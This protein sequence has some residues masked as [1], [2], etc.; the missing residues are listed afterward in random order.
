MRR[1]DGSHGEGGGQIL[2]SALALSILT[3][4]A[5]E[6]HD[7]RAGRS[8]PGLMPQHLKAVNAAAA[9]SKATVQGAVQG[10]T[11]LV[12]EPGPVRSGTWCF[13]IGTA[14]A[15]SLVLQTI[16]LPLAFAAG[17]SRVTVTGGT[18][19][20]WSPCYHYLAEQWIPWMRQ[21]GVQ[22]DVNMERAGF[23]PR[24]GGMIEARI[25]PAKELKPLQ[26]MERGSLRRI[27]ILSMVADLPESIALRQGRA[28]ED[29]LASWGGERET[30]V[31]TVP[32]AG[33]G[34][35]LFLRADF[36]GGHCSYF[37]LGARGKPAEQV[38]SEAAQALGAFLKSGAAVD[39]H[40]ADQ[41]VLPL[42]L[43]GG[44]S[45][46]RTSCVTRHLLT[47]IWVT[48]QFLPAGI[49]VEG[50]PGAPG[51]VRI[52]GVERRPRS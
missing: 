32:A 22:A 18:H 26:L 11:S 10:S 13:E 50:V 17:P 46:Y 42:A 34:T 49:A 9:V 24:G 31:L 36:E 40:G 44:E 4:E 8:R 1:I 37:A 15:T 35:M 33:K 39:E 19:V 5:M 43:A 6:V 25:A 7:I 2:R 12:F 16:F 38:A 14:G 23:Y 51:T 48:R 41:L 20:P 28:A 29:L 47:N 3:G 30:A 45:A 52:Q 27:K 21:A